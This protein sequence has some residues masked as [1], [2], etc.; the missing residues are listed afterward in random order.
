M[1]GLF[2]FSLLSSYSSVLSE[3]VDD[4]GAGSSPPSSLL[5]ICA[6]E[7]PDRTKELEARLCLLFILIRVRDPETLS[8][9]F[10]LPSPTAAAESCPPDRSSSNTGI[11]TLSRL[12]SV[13]GLEPGTGLYCTIAK[14]VEELRGI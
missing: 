11:S 9:T 13:L 1:H 6:S 14:R 7:L 8:T 2:F 4:D 12:E 10:P 3:P 5:S